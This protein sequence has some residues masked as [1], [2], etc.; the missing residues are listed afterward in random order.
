MMGVQSILCA[1]VCIVHINLKFSCDRQFPHYTLIKIVP[2][3]VIARSIAFLS[4]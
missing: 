1:F 3:D 4:D 2:F